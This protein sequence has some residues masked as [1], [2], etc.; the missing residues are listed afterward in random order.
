MRLGS[1]RGWFSGRVFKRL[2]QYAVMFHGSRNRNHVRECLNIRAHM[3]HGWAAECMDSIAR[4][5]LVNPTGFEGR[6]DA[7]DRFNEHEVCQ[8]KAMMHPSSTFSPMSFPAAILLS[9][10]PV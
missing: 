6:F 1:C 3:K 8:L 5:C 9:A 4:S 2:E 7:L 10:L